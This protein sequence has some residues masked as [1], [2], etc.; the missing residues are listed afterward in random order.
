MLKKDGS[1]LFA[2][3][4][5]LLCGCA[6]TIRV[7]KNSALER[8]SYGVADYSAGTLSGSTM[9][10]LQNFMLSGLYNKDPGQVLSRLENLYKQENRK[11]FVLL[12]FGGPVSR[13]RVRASVCK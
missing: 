13:K 3:A 12:R 2:A 9:N 7:E 4:L 1:V 8:R 11:E 6:S 5:I 10:L